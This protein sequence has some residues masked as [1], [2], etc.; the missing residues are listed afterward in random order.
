MT[1]CFRLILIPSHR[2]PIGSFVQDSTL[3]DSSMGTMSPPMSVNST[4]PRPSILGREVHRRQS[5]ACGDARRPQRCVMVRV[6]GS[7]SSTAWVFLGSTDEKQE[8][9]NSMKTKA[10]EPFWCRSREVNEVA[11]QLSILFLGTKYAMDFHMTP[12]A[13]GSSFRH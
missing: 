5:D 11:D 7:S 13:R 12:F 2:R 9:P 3:S 1:F 4:T 8:H 10:C 6:G